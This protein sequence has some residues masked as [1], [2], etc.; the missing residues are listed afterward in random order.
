MGMEDIIKEIKTKASREV[1]KIR[2]EAVKER[3]KITKETEKKAERVKNEQLEEFKREAEN[4]KRQRIIKVRMEEKRKLLE[5]K[6]EIMDRLFGQAREELN[7]LH[8]D[9]YL[10]LLKESLFSHLDSQDDEIIV[11]PRDKE[12][13]KKNLLEKL[14][15]NSKLKMK[16]G[17]KLS[18]ELDDRKGGFI[19]KK[20]NKQVNCTFSAIFASL[21]ERLEMEVASRLFD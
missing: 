8:R 18:P 2:Q 16:K 11:A 4:E 21:R 13:I 6:R 9:E 15:E 17:L 19:L 7:S 12:W 1:K 20:E 14:R 3:E 5:L 10:N